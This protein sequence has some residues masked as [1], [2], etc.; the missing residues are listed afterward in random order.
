[1]LKDL[2]SSSNIEWCMKSKP[3]VKSAENIRRT[4]S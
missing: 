4:V 3:L 1:M 2:S